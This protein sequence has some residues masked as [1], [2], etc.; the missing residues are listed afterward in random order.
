M[1]THT[2][3]IFQK[4]RF[5]RSSYTHWTKHVDVEIEFVAFDGSSIVEQ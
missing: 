4:Q 2:S 1:N 3:P 5:Q